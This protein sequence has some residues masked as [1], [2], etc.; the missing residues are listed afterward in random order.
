MAVE[1]VYDSTLL[2]RIRARYEGRDGVGEADGHRLVVDVMAREFGVHSNSIYLW[3]KTFGWRRPAWYLKRRPKRPNAKGKPVRVRLLALLGE[4]A[5]SASPVPSNRALAPRFACSP[6]GIV[7]A[8]RVLHQCG[9]IVSEAKGPLRRFKVGA[10]WTAWSAAPI[11]P[12]PKH[13]RPTLE[14]PKSMPSPAALAGERRSQRD[15]TVLAALKRLAAI[16]AAFP[17]DADI[18]RQARLPEGSVNDALKRLAGQG[19]LVIEHRPPNQRRATLSAHD[20]YIGGALGWST[21]RG[22]RPVIDLA[23]ID[24]VRALQRMGRTVFDVA[25]VTGCAWGVTWSVDGKL[26][27]RDDLIAMA[28][29]KRASAIEQMRR[30]A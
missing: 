27:G 13:H 10:A 17:S 20:G 6:S 7:H 14:R 23:A 24:A 22:S 12:R 18:A 21:G 4:L 1:P 11:D 5:R 29:D 3:A 25:V 8:L 15:A 28:R 19:K 9:A 26:L 2:G 16:G 30:A